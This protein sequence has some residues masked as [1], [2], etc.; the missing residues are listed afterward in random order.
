M[1][2][3]CLQSKLNMAPVP[4]LRLG[5]GRGLCLSRG[6]SW[7]SRYKT[8]PRDTGVWTLSMAPQGGWGI[9]GCG[10]DPAGGRS[11]WGPGLRVLG[12]DHRESLAGEP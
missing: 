6:E 8:D 11:L 3:K 2:E 9:V 12:C 10:G 4:G 7:S 1:S 5:W